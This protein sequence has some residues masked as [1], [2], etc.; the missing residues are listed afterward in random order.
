MP[1]KPTIRLVKG[2]YAEPATLAFPVKA[3]V[4][5]AY[6]RLA[7]DLLMAAAKGESFPVFGTHD[8]VLIGRITTRAAELGVKDGGYEIH[9]LYGIRGADQRMLIADGRRVRC[10][11][12]YGDAWFAWYM[13]RLAER[14]AN[15]W[16][17]V[18]SLLPG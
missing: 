18:K 2:A 1:L 4:D 8:M 14:P 12:S 6:M 3:D 10:L 5:A 17:V 11:I 15:V 9:M 13:R 16:F 7:S